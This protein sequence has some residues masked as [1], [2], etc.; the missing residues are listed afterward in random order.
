MFLT[1]NHNGK[2]TV[3]A[4]FTPIRIVCNNTLNAA[5]KQNSNKI[6]VMHN[7]GVKDRL[8][9]AHK[10]MGIV[11]KMKEELESVFN[12]MARKPIVDEQLKQIIIATFAT[13]NQLDVL[14]NGAKT[15]AEHASMTKLQSIVSD[16]Y[17]YGLNS[18]TQQTETTKGTV[19]GIYNAVTG[20]IQNVREISNQESQLMSIVDGSGLDYSQKAFNLC[21][22]LVK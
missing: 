5:M 8:K 11:N 20:Y 10:T 21:L 19:F 6:R 14:A 7:A 9:E 17:A 3:T 1:N 13:K 22:D 16:A 2:G 4:A 18:D 15:A 12:I